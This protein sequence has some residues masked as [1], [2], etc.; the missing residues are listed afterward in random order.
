MVQL[1]GQT[2]IENLVD[3]GRFAGARYAGN[4]GQRPQGDFCRDILQIVLPAAG[5]PQKTG[6]LPGRRSLGTSIFR[7]PD[8]YCPVR[9]RGSFIRSSTEPVAT[10]SPP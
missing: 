7:T 3:Q 6:P 1:G 5:D 4:T 8:R 2:L 9:E 10:I